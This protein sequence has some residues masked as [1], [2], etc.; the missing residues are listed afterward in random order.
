[1]FA[2]DILLV[3]EASASS[4]ATILQIL[5]LFSP[6]F[7]QTINMA[8]S[9]VFFSQNTPQPEVEALAF[10]LGSPLSRTWGVTLGS[11]YSQGGRKKMIIPF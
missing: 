9:G 4:V 10:N 7:G 11:L 1:M 3:A 6:F 5:D 2:D 8:K